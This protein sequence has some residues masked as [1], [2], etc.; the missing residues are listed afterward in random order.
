LN[1][2]Y[3]DASALAKRYV[4]ETGSPLVNQFADNL[5]SSRLFF[6]GQAVGEVVSILVRRRNSRLI[7][8]DACR[9]IVQ[10]VRAELLLNSKFTPLQ[11]D[12]Q[13]VVGSLPFVERHS[14]NSTD[15]LVLAS[16]LGVAM[17]VRADGDDLVLVASDQRLLRAAKSENLRVFD[18]ESGTAA[19]LHALVNAR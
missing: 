1:C 18:P 15:G 11:T 4:A 3:F 7:T 16:A 8:A 9:K 14:I 12:P 17:A 5:P 2:F 19:E 10:V 6:L 13:L